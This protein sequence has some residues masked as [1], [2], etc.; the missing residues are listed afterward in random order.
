MTLTVTLQAFESAIL[1]GVVATKQKGLSLEK[2]YVFGSVSN[3][4]HVEDNRLF[5]TLSYC[6]VVFM[7]NAYTN[8]GLVTRDKRVT[9]R[10]GLQ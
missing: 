7:C 1:G 5:W 8:V 10:K 9:F 2:N 3:L 4:D 6:N